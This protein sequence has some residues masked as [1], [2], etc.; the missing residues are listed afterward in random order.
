MSSIQLRL[1]IPEKVSTNKAYRGFGHW[2]E[3]SK[4][5]TIYHQAMLQFKGK[6]KL[7]KFPVDIV[8]DFY[9]KGRALD[10]SNQSFMGK[11][12]E[13]GLVQ[14]GLLP[15]DTPTYVKSS[16]YITSKADKTDEDCV[17]ITIEPSA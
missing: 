4:L 17:F 5:A 15:D 6:Y 13:D 10:S 8:Y 2:S 14:I 16:K 1:A 12:M 7:S 11:M 9:W 3:R